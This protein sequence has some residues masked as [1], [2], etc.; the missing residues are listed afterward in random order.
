MFIATIAITILLQVFFTAGLILI[1]RMLA[2]DNPSAMPKFFFAATA[3]RLVIS[4]IVFFVCIYLIRGDIE[5]IKT[6]TVTIL[7]SYALL[8]MIDI[9]YFVRTS[10]K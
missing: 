3:L 6:L 2:K 1:W 5:H 8:H 9:I 10:T 7:A 4:V